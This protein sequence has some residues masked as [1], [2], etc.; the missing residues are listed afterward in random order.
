[1]H[2][3]PILIWSFSCLPP[4]LN[5]GRLRVGHLMMPP[6][7][8]KL[9][10]KGTWI[11]IDIHACTQWLRNCQNDFILLILTS[12][13]FFMQWSLML[14]NIQDSHPFYTTRM[15]EFYHTWPLGQKWDWDASSDKSHFPVAQGPPGGI[16]GDLL[17]DLKVDIHTYTIIMFDPIDLVKL[18]NRRA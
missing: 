2:V 12:H 6:S 7:A 13:A 16:C 18:A 17:V 5:Q 1:M 3:G 9:W 15:I 8:I 10:E 11:A 4:F 14:P